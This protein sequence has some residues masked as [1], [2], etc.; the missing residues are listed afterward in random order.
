MQ[1]LDLNPVQH[2]HEG[3]GDSVKVKEPEPEVKEPG[4]QSSGGR[5]GDCK[6]FFMEIVK[7]KT[8]IYSTKPVALK[9]PWTFWID[10]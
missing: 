9:S 4:V 5:G 7:R 10:R 3:D 1:K 8:N 6:E 2:E